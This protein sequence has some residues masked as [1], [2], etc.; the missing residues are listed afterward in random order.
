MR[1]MTTG[2][3]SNKYKVQTRAARAQFGEP[4]LNLDEIAEKLGVP[5]GKM[6]LDLGVNRS[7]G[8][9]EPARKS[10]TSGKHLYRLS[11]FKKYFKNRQATQ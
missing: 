11:D 3:I 10:T 5:A 9:P 4:L 6:R 1:D 2:I 7:E 8:A